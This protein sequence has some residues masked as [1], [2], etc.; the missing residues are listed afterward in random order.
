MV[1]RS[2]A[3]SPVDF[4]LLSGLQAAYSA[5]QLQK[6]LNLAANGLRQHAWGRIYISRGLSTVA[7]GIEPPEPPVSLHPGSTQVHIPN[8]IWIASAVSAEVMVVTNTQT[9]FRTDTTYCYICSNRPHL[10]NACMR[11]GLIM[12]FSDK[13]LHHY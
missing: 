4:S 10:S 5:K 2:V 3:S 12:K 7:W 13:K 1:W 6:S 11:C 8:R 9:G